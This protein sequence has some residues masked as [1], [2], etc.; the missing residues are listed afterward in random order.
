MTPGL[1]A[2]LNIVQI[3][4]VEPTEIPS[5]SYL[6]GVQA[7]TGV[8]A[9]SNSEAGSDLIPY[10]QALRANQSVDSSSSMAL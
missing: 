7:I 3:A 1:Y 8:K 5:R 2:R 10:V 6:K 9:K 4:R